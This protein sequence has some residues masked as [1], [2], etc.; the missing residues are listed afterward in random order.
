MTSSS[1]ALN[2]NQDF[3]YDAPTTPIR[4]TNNAAITP[5]SQLGTRHSLVH[6]FTHSHHF[7]IVDKLSSIDVNKLSAGQ[8]DLLQRAYDSLNDFFR[9]LQNEPVA[10]HHD[11]S[12]LLDK[13]IMASPRY[14]ILY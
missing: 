5:H 9:L 4:Y 3:T 12:N 2:W 13:T 14:H 6:S 1:T 10:S 11:E 7:L 8:T